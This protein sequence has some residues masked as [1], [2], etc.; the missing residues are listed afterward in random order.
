MITAKDNIIDHYALY[1]TYFNMELL[2]K[3]FF[4][5]ENIDWDFYII[6]DLDFGTKFQIGENDL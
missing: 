1:Q 3:D 2:Y 6:N 4:E 5:N